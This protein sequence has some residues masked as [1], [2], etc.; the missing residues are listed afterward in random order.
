MREAGTH[1]GVSGADVAQASQVDT[2][3]LLRR[4]GYGASTLSPASAPEA[5]ERRE[6]Q[7]PVAVG[8]PG[9]TAEVQSPTGESGCAGRRRLSKNLAL[10]YLDALTFKLAQHVDDSG[11]PDACWP[12][13]AGVD[14]DGYGRLYVGDEE[15]RAHRCALEV[16]LGRRL[17][18]DE[19]ARHKVCDNPPCCNPA[20]LEAGTTEDNNRD[21]Q[22]RGRQARGERSGSAKLTDVQ[23]DEIRRACVGAPYG[24]Y[25]QLARKYGISSRQVSYIAKGERRGVA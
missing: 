12:W 20:H 5:Q 4:T 25:S 23:A 11:G 6:K 1:V 10:P 9:A 18:A 22:E 24:V 3:G 7:W 16:K 19:V 21:M 17:A 2:C 13:T 8:A 15:L 14:L